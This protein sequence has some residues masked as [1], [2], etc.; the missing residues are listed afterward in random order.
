MCM[1]FQGTPDFDYSGHFSNPVSSTLRPM[2]PNTNRMGNNEITKQLLL[3]GRE[4]KN[5]IARRIP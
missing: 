3:I 4:Y 1:Y 2:K 5:N